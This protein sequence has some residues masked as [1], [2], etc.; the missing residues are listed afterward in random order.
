M[1][2]KDLKWNCGFRKQKTTAFQ[3]ANETNNKLHEPVTWY[4]NENHTQST[5]HI[6]NLHARAK[7]IG[8]TMECLET[9]KIVFWAIKFRQNNTVNVIWSDESSLTEFSTNRRVYVWKIPV[10]DYNVEYLFQTNKQRMDVILQW[11][12]RVYHGFSSI[13]CPPWAGYSADLC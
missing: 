8:A 10:Q 12:A 7:T 1:G 5:Q 11:K 4:V 9:T 13:D 2:I 6:E 3:I